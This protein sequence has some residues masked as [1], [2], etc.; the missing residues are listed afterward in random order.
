MY[1]YA[2]LVT[3]SYCGLLLFTAIYCYLRLSTAVNS[4][5]RVGDICGLGLTLARA[6]F[7]LPA[8]DGYFGFDGNFYFDAGQSG[9]PE[10]EMVVST[11]KD[12]GATFG[13]GKVYG[14]GVQGEY[15][16]RVLLRALG[17]FRTFTARVDISTAFEMPIYSDAKIRVA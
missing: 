2:L 10:P 14:M 17:Q 11:S 15:E 12:G 3:A 6:G 5:C 7:F 8:A 9:A 4:F 16:K 1:S 13:A